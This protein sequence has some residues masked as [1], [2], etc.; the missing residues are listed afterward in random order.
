VHQRQRGFLSL[1]LIAIAVVLL[2][3]TPLP[4]QTPATGALAGV[5]VDPTGSL[6]PGVVGHL[7]NED[8]NA[9]RDSLEEFKVQTG[10]YDA[11]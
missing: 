9:S 5:A 11:G 10:L 1:G 8:T 6:I 4:S 7:T 3:S 2:I